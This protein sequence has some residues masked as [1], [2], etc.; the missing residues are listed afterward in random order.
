LPRRKYL[1]GRNLAGSART[2]V[3]S[4]LHEPTEI[5]PKQPESTRARENPHFRFFTRWEELIT[6]AGRLDGLKDAPV[7][8]VPLALSTYTYLPLFQR[9]LNELGYS[10][11]LSGKTT[12]QI[13]QSSAGICGGEFCFPAKA[14]LGHVRKLVETEGSE[15]IFLPHVISAPPNSYT[16]NAYFCPYVQ[17]FPSIARASLEING[18]DSSRIISPVIDF[19]LPEHL[20]VRELCRSIGAPLGKSDSRIEAAWK[21]AV[22]AQEQFTAACAI[23]GERAVSVIRR[24]GEKAIVVLGRPY[25]VHDLGMNLGL[26]RKIAELGYTVIP[27]DFLAESVLQ[28]G[29]PFKNLYWSHAQKIIRAVNKIQSTDLLHAVYFT[30]FNCGPDSFVESYAR[31]LFGE[32]PM[33]VLELDEHEA[34][35]GY[36]TRIEAFLDVVKCAPP[37]RNFPEIV[38][39]PSSDSEFRRRKI[40]IPRL[41]PVA[42]PLFAAAFR[43]F[44]YKAEVLPLE[45]Y[46]VFIRWQH[47]CSL[48][49]SGLLATTPRCYLWKTKKRLKSAVGLPLVRSACRWSQQSGRSLR[50]SGTPIQS[51]VKP[52]TLCP[53]QAVPAGS[54][55][56]L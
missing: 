13:R 52:P 43:S 55:S 7:V 26:V 36:I 54:V 9:F 15:P 17:S 47:R 40:W 49:L 10:V 38:F 45:G 33:L 35:A 14:A 32:K 34:D 37:I 8:A 22:A 30:N 23:E 31:Q 19:R 4:L 50:N 25:N 53:W 27:L 56:T 41:H 16:T 24:R 1:C 51:P 3:R 48:R 20:Q 42:A 2:A 18:L 21:E 11:R 12:R 6:K 5:V 29:E 28:L 39:P 44:G 46:P